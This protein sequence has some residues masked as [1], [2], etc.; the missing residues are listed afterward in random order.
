MTDQQFLAWIAGDDCIRCALVEVAVRIGGAES[1]LYLSNRPYTTG[2]TDTPAHT[3][4]D[5]CIV[6]GISHTAALDLQGGQAR[7]GVGDIEIDNT[8]GSRDSWLVH[9]WRNRAVKVWIGDVRWARADFRLVF[10]GVVSDIASSGPAALTLT[11]LDKLERLNAPISDATVEGIGPNADKL[12]PLTFGEAFN[13]QPLLVDSAALRYQVHA[14]RIQGLIEVRDNGAPVGYTADTA[15]GTF[16]LGS[17]PVGV[18]TCSVQGDAPGGSYANGIAAIV[19]RLATN[20]GP[21]ATRFTAADLDAD[22]LAAFAAACPQPVGLHVPDRG[23]VLQASQDLAAS[24][25]AQVVM[26]SLGKLRLVRLALPAA[27]TPTAIGPADLEEDGLSVAERPQVRAAVRLGWCR[28][29]TVQTSGLAGGLPPDSQALMGTEWLEVVRSDADV[30]SLYRLEAEPELEPTLLLTELDATREADRRLALWSSARTVY[31][32]RGLA[33]LLLLELGSPVTLSH[34]RWG[35]S[36]GAA[37]VVVSVERDWLAGRCT[38]GILAGGAA[39]AAPAPAPTPAPG[40]A[41]TTAPVLTGTISISGLTT[42]SYTA[43]CPAATDN[44]GVAGYEWSLDGGASYILTS[45]IPTRTITGRTAGSTDQLRVRAYDAAG[46]RS[47]ALALPVTLEAAAPAPAPAPGRSYPIPAVGQCV[48]ISGNTAADVTPT[49]EGWTSDAWLESLFESFGGPAFAPGYSAEGAVVFSGGGHD[50]PDNVGAA[51]FDFA[52]G[53]WSRL[54]NA[55][56][57]ARPDAGSRTY[58]VQPAATNGAPWYELLGSEVPA[59]PHPYGTLAYCPDGARGSVLWVTRAA[60]TVDGNLSSPTAHR[61]DLATRAW[62]RY[63]Q[64]QASRVGVE[65]DALWDETRNR[66]WHLLSAQNNFR[67]VAYLDR[68]NQTWGLSASQAS[69][70]SSSITG[71]ASAQYSRNWLFR[72]LILRAAN[73]ALWCWDPD[74]ATTGWRALAVT[75]TV[76]TLTFAGHSDGCL[77]AFA[78]ASASNTITRL[79]PPADLAQL[80]TGTWVVE[81][82]TIGGA[83]LPARAGRQDPAPTNHYRRFGAVPALD[84]LYWI[85]GGTKAVYLLKPP[86]L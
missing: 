75:G 19:Q 26:T 9:V 61:F 35:L 59:P 76:P 28:A 21:P 17:S 18:I 13:V 47:T 73:G 3:A 27:G 10:D 38:L 1:V 5:A 31:R 78:G 16:V 55:N 42:T 82:V 22:A 25:G 70:P 50:H 8:D 23:S 30:A 54:D 45:T 34:P 12:I 48:A 53:L 57:V 69:F 65:A 60:V 71:S 67:N 52:T 86:A 66:W 80:K 83:A 56:G 32:A 79:R 64:F 49:H 37:G 39:V 2:A 51:V 29:W 20:Y 77:Y 84:C 24:V 62:S 40:T 41:D 58:S 43:S 33:H 85:P 72:G 36:A 14:G 11:L 81:S 63:S 44:V 6:G 15:A 7:I 68:S 46:N 4:Y 74:D